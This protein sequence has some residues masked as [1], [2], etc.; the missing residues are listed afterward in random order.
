MLL[1]LPHM[2][3][4]IIHVFQKKQGRN[5]YASDL[6][7]ARGNSLLELVKA[8][9]YVGT[10]LFLQLCWCLPGARSMHMLLLSAVRNKR[11]KSNCSAHNGLC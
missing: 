4:L 5:D 11:A 10:C 7:F 9:T 6:D 1:Q 8:Q 2:S 3:S